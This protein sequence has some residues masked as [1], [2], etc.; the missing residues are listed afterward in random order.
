[1]CHGCLRHGIGLEFLLQILHIVGQLRAVQRLHQGQIGVHHALRVKHLKRVRVFGSCGGHDRHVAFRS[2]RCGNIRHRD[3]IDIDHED[4]PVGQDFRTV[5]DSDN[6]VLHLYL[7]SGGYFN[8]ISL[9]SIGAVVVFGYDS[10]LKNLLRVRQ[11]SRGLGGGHSL[12]R[13]K[14]LVHQRKPAA[15]HRHLNVIL[16]GDIRRVSIGI[17][18]AAQLEAKAVV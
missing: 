16:I 17:C 15:V 1:M 18:T 14:F 13:Q 12:L 2:H 9:E 4:A 3:L 10:A 7:S 8:H 6:T 5:G 11:H